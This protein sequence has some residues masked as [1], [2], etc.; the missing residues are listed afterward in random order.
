MAR[1][2]ALVNRTPIEE[3]RAFLSGAILG[4]GDAMKRLLCAVRRGRLGGG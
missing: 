3:Q 4:D 2:R 1:P